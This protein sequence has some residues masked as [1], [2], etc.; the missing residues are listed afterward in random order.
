MPSDK[1]NSITA[2]TTGL[3]FSLF[4]VASAQEVPFGIPQYVKCIFSWH[5]GNW[6]GGG[7]MGLK[8]PRSGEGGLA[9][10]E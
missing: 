9:S 6:G 1:C 10:S 5:G 3:I 7:A 2:K 8:P 4:D